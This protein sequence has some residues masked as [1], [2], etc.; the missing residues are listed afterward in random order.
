M[1][2]PTAP[3]APSVQTPATGLSTG[4]IVLL[5]ALVFGVLRQGA[6]HQW[7]HQV[8]AALVLGVGLVMLTRAPDRSSL[9]GAALIISPLVVSSLVSTALSNDRGDAGSTFLTLAL[10]AIALA[11]GRSVLPSRRDL[12]TDGVL[13]VAAIVAVT[14]IW[15]VATHTTPWGRITEGVWR[16]SSSLTYA[17]AAAAV[18]G[19]AAVLAFG[20]A[21]L[22]GRRAYAVLSTLFLVGFISTQSRGGALA[23]LIISIAALALAGI[24]RTGQIAPSILAGTA[25]GAVPL[26]AFAGDA[27]QPRT[28]VVLAAVLAGLAVTYVAMGFQEQ[29]PHPGVSLAAL[30]VAA[31]GTVAFTDL[32][33]PLTERLTLRSG[34]TAGGEDAAVLFGDRAKEWSTAWDLVVDAPLVGHGPGVVDLRWTEDERA[35]QALFVH[36]EYLELAVTHGVLGIL[37]L[38]VS[39]ALLIRRRSRLLTLWPNTLAI[40]GYLLHSG[41]DFLWHVPALPVLFAFLAGLTLEPTGPYASGIPNSGESTLQ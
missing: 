29:M 31:I 41:V 38:A 28:A 16:G 1:S 25:V 19:P 37:A 21:A 35:F 27:G 23:L 36:N 26:L 7:Q 4:A 39:G 12:A 5:G 3:A 40:V 8:F 24:A 15:G 22:T 30:V 20:R 34:T 17:N 11:A 9:V 6:Y 13:L 33:A 2:A 14:A 18:V 32:A 10:V